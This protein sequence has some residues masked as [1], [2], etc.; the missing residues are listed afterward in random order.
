MCTTSTFLVLSFFA[1][2]LHRCW[3]HFLAHFCFQSPPKPHQKTFKKT[4]RFLHRF[5][6]DFRWIWDTIFEPS[7]PILAPS[8]PSRPLLKLF[9]ALLGASLAPRGPPGAPRRLPG[10][11]GPPFSTIFGPLLEGF[12]SRFH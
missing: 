7:W 3:H 12:S 8:W 1:C 6:N 11:P 9:L 2:F 5:F 4:T 10:S